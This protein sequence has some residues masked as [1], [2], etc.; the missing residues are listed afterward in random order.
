[1]YINV[2]EGSIKSK[3][4]S[5]DSNITDISSYIKDL[6]ANVSE[7]SN[8]WKGSDH[9]Y[10][11]TQMETFFKDMEK[12]EKSIRSYNNYVNGYLTTADK[13]NSHYGN[14]RINLK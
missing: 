2:N 5:I 9:T 8:Y 3:T 7:I 12:L 11:A 14:K 4:S 6:K 13:L 1:M 10:F